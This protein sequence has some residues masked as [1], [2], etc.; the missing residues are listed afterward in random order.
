MPHLSDQLKE[1]C[2]NLDQR[3]FQNI[4]IG[5]GPAGLSMA[6]EFSKRGISYILLEANDAPGGQWDRL[7]VCGQLI[8]LNKRYVPC[9]NHTYRMRYDWH[10]LS[11]ISTEDA[12]KDPK[13]RFT[14]W[15]SEHWP[16]ARLT[17]PIFNM[18]PRKWTL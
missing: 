11:A 13:L 18:W 14:E 7:P 2:T 1:E 15:T 3:H 6:L 9:D 17:K 10:T 8:S 12:A 4:I 16:S 5:G